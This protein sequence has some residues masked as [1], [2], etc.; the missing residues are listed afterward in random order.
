LINPVVAGGGVNVKHYK[1]AK[2]V[3]QKIY[4]G[5]HIPEVMSTRDS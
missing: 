2:E 1:H 4:S 3:H 5:G